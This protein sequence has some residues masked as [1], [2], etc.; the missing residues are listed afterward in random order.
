MW[1]LHLYALPYFAGMTG[2]LFQTEGTILNK[3][4]QNTA[5]KDL[6]MLNFNKIP[7]Y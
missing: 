3:L 5:M 2:C 1:L 6:N 7:H 4:S